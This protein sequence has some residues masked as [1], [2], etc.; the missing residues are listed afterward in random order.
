MVGNDLDNAVLGG[1]SDYISDIVTNMYK[2]FLAKEDEKVIF[3]CVF[4]I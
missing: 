1:S 3:G 2:V 4:H